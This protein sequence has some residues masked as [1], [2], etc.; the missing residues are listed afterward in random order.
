MNRGPLLKNYPNPIYYNNIMPLQYNDF[1]GPRANPDRLKKL[2]HIYASPN[3]H[4]FKFN[5][6]TLFSLFFCGLF[7]YILW[8]KYKKSKEV[9]ELSYNPYKF[10]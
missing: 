10:S 8:F 6:S 7:F 3:D 9:D 2:S 5:L 1:K 4:S